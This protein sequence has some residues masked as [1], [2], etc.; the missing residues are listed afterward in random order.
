MKIQWLRM[1]YHI[2]KFSKIFAPY[3]HNWI[4]WLIQEIFQ[5]TITNLMN[6]KN[7]WSFFQIRNKRQTITARTDQNLLFKEKICLS[8]MHFIKIQLTIW[9]IFQITQ[10]RL[11]MFNILINKDHNIVRH[12][13][14]T[15]AFIEQLG[16]KKIQRPKKVIATFLCICVLL[17]EF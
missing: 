2:R 9:K 8:I 3:Q 16:L 6:I 11:R 1:A 13:T 15:L 10:M 12:I 17:L 4:Q 7:L 14:M 5:I